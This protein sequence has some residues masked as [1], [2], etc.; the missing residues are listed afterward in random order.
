MI[1]QHR[2]QSVIAAFQCTTIV[3]GTIAVA[4]MLK[5]AGY[6]DSRDTWPQMPVFIRDWGLIFLFIPLGWVVFTIWLEHKKEYECSRVF[7]MISGLIVL[8]LLFFFF[9]G[10]AARAVVSPFGGI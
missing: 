2:V 6:P 8:G 9:L 3:F 5:A 1:A 10:Q 7:V 4:T